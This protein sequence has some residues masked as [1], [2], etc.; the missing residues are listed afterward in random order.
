MVSKGT[1]QTSPESAASRFAEAF[2]FLT[3]NPTAHIYYCLKGER[4][5]DRKLQQHYPDVCSAED[6]EAL[7]SPLRTTVLYLDVV[8]KATEWPTRDN[9]IKSLAKHLGFS[10]R[11]PHPSRAASIERFDRR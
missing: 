9:S 7:S 4:T 6:V 5:I 8:M 1:T 3:T 10:R 2:E 11:D